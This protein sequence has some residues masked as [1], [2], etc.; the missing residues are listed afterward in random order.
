MEPC[1][2]EGKTELG[3]DHYEIRTY[4]GWHHH[5][6]MTLLAHCL[7]WHLKLP[8]GKKALALPVA[9]VR[10]LVEVVIPL[11]TSTVEGVLTVSAWVPQRT[12]Q[13]YRAPRARRQEDG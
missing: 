4:A 13:A 1:C 6:L 8:V 5:R 10:T 7:L 9:Q 12:H 3:M 11:R 2:E